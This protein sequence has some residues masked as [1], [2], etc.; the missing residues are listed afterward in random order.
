[1]ETHSRILDWKI[2]WIEEPGG[3]QFMGSY[4]VTHN[5]ATLLTQILNLLPKQQNMWRICILAP[6]LQ[7]PAFYCPGLNNRQLKRA[8]G[9]WTIMYNFGI[10]GTKYIQGHKEEAILTGSSS[11]KPREESELRGL[12]SW[13]IT[14]KAWECLTD[15]QEIT[16]KQRNQI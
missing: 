10:T 13:L 6:I 9:L 3:L 8:E 5:W 14:T 7:K 2:P 16:I 11:W 15:N 1:M 4:R 12:L